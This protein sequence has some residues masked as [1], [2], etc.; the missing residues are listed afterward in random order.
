M[1]QKNDDCTICFPTCILILYISIF[2]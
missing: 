2:I 1:T